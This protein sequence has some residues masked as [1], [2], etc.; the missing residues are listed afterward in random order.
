M[1]RGHSKHKVTISFTAG[2][3]ERNHRACVMRG[4]RGASGAHG[5]SPAPTH[6]PPSVARN[7]QNDTLIQQPHITERSQGTQGQ[8]SQCSPKAG[9]PAHLTV[10]VGQRGIHRRRLGQEGDEG[11]VLRRCRHCKPELPQLDAGIAENN[12]LLPPLDDKRLIPQL[13]QQDRRPARQRH[14]QASGGRK[15][16]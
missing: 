3:V 4:R 14:T 13:A 12:Y 15:V 1:A 5:V 9:I 11:G 6:P 10:A 16:E 8:G 2:F 7:M